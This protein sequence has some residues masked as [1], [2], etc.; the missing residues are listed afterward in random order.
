MT[1]GVAGPITGCHAHVYYDR[2]SRAAAA[3]FRA[4][5]DRTFSV[6]LRRW[7]ERAGRS[8]PALDGPGGLRRRIRFAELVPWLM[9]HRAGLVALVH[10]LT[11][12]DR[13]DH[14][15]HALWLGNML[16]LDLDALESA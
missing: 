10:P 8:A 3:Q 5:L 12:D 11:G 9:L 16:A 6:H 2:G 7:R 13:A 4:D 14:D 15:A 1:A